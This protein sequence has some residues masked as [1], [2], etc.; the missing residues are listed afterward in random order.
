MHRSLSPLR[1][2][3]RFGQYKTSNMS[4][5]SSTSTVQQNGPPGM[6]PQNNNIPTSSAS[7]T[8][9]SS[10]PASNATS[11]SSPNTTN[12]SR[13][14]GATESPDMSAKDKRSKGSTDT[15][16]PSPPAAKNGTSNSH[17]KSNADGTASA[18]TSSSNSDRL[19]GEEATKYVFLGRLHALLTPLC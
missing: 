13:K 19:W 5:P 4:A 11:I 8:T 12:T 16:R 14:R 15:S 7:S 2:G 17:G 1:T 10:H 18:S 3:R 9:S 6:I